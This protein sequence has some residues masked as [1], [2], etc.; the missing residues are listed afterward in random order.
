MVLNNNR[1][2]NINDYRCER[3]SNRYIVSV[4]EKNI[5]KENTKRNMTVKIKIKMQYFNN[6]NEGRYPRYFLAFILHSMHFTP[7]ESGHI[8]QKC[9]RLGPYPD[10]PY[11][12]WISTRGKCNGLS[13]QC[14]KA[15]A[16]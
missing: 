4:K 6:I 7:T 2:P 11:F 16:C 8:M 5:I 10:L 1:S 13:C 14:A 15:V 9:R 3:G 12:C